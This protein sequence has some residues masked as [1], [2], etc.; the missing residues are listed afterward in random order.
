MKPSISKLLSVVALFV[1][2]TSCK[3]GLLDFAGG[4]Q[5]E[6]SS[7]HGIIVLGEQLEDPYSLANMTKAFESLYPT[8]AG[9]VS[10]EATNNYVRLLPRDD[11]DFKALESLGVKML[12]HPLDYQIL[13]EGDY[14]HDPSIDDEEVT[15]QYAVVSPDF[16][17]P[18]GIRC[19][20]LHECYLAEPEQSSKA[21]LD[22]VDWSAVERE[23]FRL[24]GNE[25]MLEP[26]TKGKS[27]AKVPKGR[28]CI[29]DSE[30]GDDPIGVSGV[31]V[32]CNVFVRFDRCFTDEEGYYQM[33]KSFSS[34]PRYRLVFTNSKGFSQGFNTIFIRGS[35]SSF[36]KQPNTGYSTVITEKSESTLF[37]RCVINN[38]AYDYYESCSSSGV[39]IKTP[40]ANLRIWS[41]GFLDGS[42]ALM[43]HQSAIISMDVIKSFV[44]EYYPVVSFFMPDIVIGA[45]NRNTYSDLYHVVQHELAHASHYMMVGNDYWN[46]YAM[47]ILDSYISSGKV[48]YGTGTEDNAGVCEVGEMWAYY[49][50]NLL[51]RERYPNWIK[52]FGDAYWFH[53]EIFLYL[54]RRG[55]DRFKIFPVLTRDVTSKEILR[56]RLISFYPECRSMIDEA[57][58]RYL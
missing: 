27:E 41:F 58:N 54:D 22:W 7:E 45:K 35:I 50:E 21:G 25:D 42:A 20:L 39:K 44:G 3:D 8:K 6:S 52:S 38:A 40:P 14:Y 4:Y 36:G 24:T 47:F 16:K 19:E 33:R 17:A 34:K 48:L 10:L 43:M 37:R 57:F 28:I 29:I 13:V 12:D 51:Y 56:S 32:S 26:L 31:E 18:D 23:S 49:I 55:M 30:Y 11:D 53:P 15:W 2:L 9:V 1:S 5:Y 46:T